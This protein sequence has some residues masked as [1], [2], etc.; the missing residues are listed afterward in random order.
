M[1]QNFR[2]TKALSEFL[3]IDHDKCHSIV[4]FWGDAEFKT[5]MPPNVMT[6][7]YATYIKSKQD[8]MFS[9]AEVDQLTEALRTGMLPKSLGNPKSACR[10]SQDALCQYH[11][12]PEMWRSLGPAD[13]P[14]RIECWSAFSMGVA[15]FPLAATWC[16]SSRQ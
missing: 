6:K 2:H 9:D 5:P 16:R 3:D 11:D 13:S 8:V 7:G 15:A 4:M 1:H 14:V 12:L 10:V